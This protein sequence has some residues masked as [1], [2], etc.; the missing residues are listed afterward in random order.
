MWSL[1][2][3]SSRSSGFSTIVAFVFFLLTAYGSLLTAQAQARD[4]VD[5]IRIDS[6]L[7][8]LSVGVAN[9]NSAAV[10]GHLEQKDFAVFEDGAPQEILF[11]ESGEAPFDLVLLLDLSASTSDKI[12][13]IRKSAK[14]FVDAVRP[15]DRIAICTFAAQLMVVSK[16]TSDHTALKQSIEGI[17]EPFGGTNFWDALRFV[18]EHVTGQSRVEKRRS[19]VIVMTDGLDN[20]LPGVPGDGSAT[21][22]EDLLKIV[23]RSD[24]IVLPIYLDTEKEQNKRGNLTEA[25]GLARQQLVTLALE[26]GNDIYQARKLK[27]LEGVYARI[28]RDLST[29]Y[30]LGYRPGNP[31]RDGSW[32]TVNVQL[33]GHPELAVRAR[34]GYYRK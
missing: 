5:V 31:V 9:R 11:F 7:V 19:A 15:G 28:I 8:N 2:P 34:H 1:S 10:T 29:V 20:A 32:R 30:S 6:D 4:N 22:F 18:V 23:Q 33:I 27:D 17:E 26:S 25:Y 3:V 21:N 14:R 24:S 13:L 16:L 12:S